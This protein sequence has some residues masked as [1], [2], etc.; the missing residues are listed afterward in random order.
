MEQ[1]GHSIPHYYGDI[2]RV[3][4]FA[5]AAISLL[6]SPVIGNLVPLDPF[7][8]IISSVALVALA[9]LTH[10]RGR[11]ILVLDTIVAALGIILVELAAVTRYSQ[12]TFALFV[13]RESVAF[14][15]LLA[16]YF[17][18]KTVR[19]MALHIIGHQDIEGEF[20]EG[21]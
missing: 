6:A 7:S 18:I 9:A 19:A 21:E 5:V 11:Y 8:Q 4:F 13:T 3:L 16:F 17:S 10:P 12:D 2:I 1:T 14:F 15:L 20:A